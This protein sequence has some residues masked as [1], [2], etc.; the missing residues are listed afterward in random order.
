MLRIEPEGAALAAQVVRVQRAGE[1]RQHERVPPLLLLARL[2]EHDLAMSGSDHVHHGVGPDPQRLGE[3]QHGRD[4]GPARPRQLAEAR[5]DRADRD[6]VGVQDRVDRQALL[7]PLA[8]DRRGP[9]ELGA[10]RLAQLP[11]RGQ[12]TGHVAADCLGERLCR[13]PP[14]VGDLSADAR[15]DRV[16]QTVQLGLDLRDEAP[17]DL[18]GGHRGRLY[19]ATSPRARDRRASAPPRR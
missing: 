10:G 3:R 5:P 16:D 13:Q 2:L 14:E 9:L 8:A 7:G 1:Q 4:V 15:P 6:A 19:C 12:R 17:D 11:Q 18:R